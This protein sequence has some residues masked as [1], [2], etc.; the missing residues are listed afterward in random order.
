MFA[1]RPVA[2]ETLNQSAKA[3]S[4]DPLP[5][6]LKA[7]L[8]HVERADKAEKNAADH[9][10]SA[11]LR[12]KQLKDRIQAGEVGKVS[13]ASYCA[14]HIPQLDQ[15]T[16]ERY[17]AIAA[18]EASNVGDDGSSD[19]QN[20]SSP[21]EDEA[22]R[23]HHFNRAM[24]WARHRHKADGTQ[25]RAETAFT[26]W[27]MDTGQHDSVYALAAWNAMCDEFNKPHGKVA[28]VADDKPE[29]S[30][31]PKRDPEAR[32]AQNAKAQAN[33]R[34][35]SSS[36]GEANGGK[37]SKPRQD[38]ETT[39]QNSR[40][41]MMAKVLTAGQLQ[42]VCDWIDSEWRGTEEKAKAAKAE[43]EKAAQLQ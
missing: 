35:K 32:K 9:R 3:T 24:D 13:W 23:R 34:A 1:D 15:R 25:F 36:I 31:K 38:R 43:R 19:P 39:E 5:V 30:A 40:L 2:D 18:G 11:G 10:T 14:Q 29:P 37:A 8:A 41:A 33:R 20:W 21:A 7:A 28:P 42:I 17:I 4:Q 12:F 27:R 26:F 6:V 22:I 16:V